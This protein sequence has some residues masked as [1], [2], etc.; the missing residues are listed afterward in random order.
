MHTQLSWTQT[1][2]K[3]IILV[4]DGSK[5]LFTSFDKNFNPTSCRHWILFHLLFAHCCLLLF[6]CQKSLPTFLEKKK[7]QLC[8]TSSLWWWIYHELAPRSLDLGTMIISRVCSRISIFKEVSGWQSKDDDD[9]PFIIS[10]TYII[11]LFKRQIILHKGIMNYRVL[12]SIT[13]RNYY[14]PLLILDLLDHFQ[15]AHIFMKLAL[16]GAY[17]LIPVRGVKMF[18]STEETATQLKE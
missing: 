9:L 10:H 11:L 3:H 2:Y 1:G 17:Y 16:R 15:K 6:P 14:P 13:I 4:F 8:P 18:N 12:S 5:K 7:L